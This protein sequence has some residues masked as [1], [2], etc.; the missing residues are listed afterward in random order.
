MCSV[1]KR[2]MSSAVWLLLRPERLSASSIVTS[3]IH[4]DDGD[5][6]EVC[7]LFEAS[8]RCAPML[9]WLLGIVVVLA[10]PSDGSGVEWRMV[11]ARTLLSSMDGPATRTIPEHLSYHLKHV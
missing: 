5:V 1:K 10:A 11:R 4:A 8:C 3:W 7:G 6:F 9:C 2:V